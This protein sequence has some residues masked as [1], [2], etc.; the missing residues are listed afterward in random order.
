MRHHRSVF[1]R[2]A[3]AMGAAAVATAAV[4]PVASAQQ[5]PVGVGT[6]TGEL[7]VLG[8]QAGSLLSIQALSDGGL[9]TTADGLGPAAAAQLDALRITSPALGIDLA[10]P[11]L[12][13]ATNGGSDA[14]GGD[15]TPIDNPVLGGS[16]LPSAL[17]ALVDDT[18]ARSSVTAGL[19]DLDLLGGLLRLAGTQLDLGSIAESTAA[20][21]TRGVDVDAL[22]VL[23]LDALLTGLGIPLSS[24]PLDSL[25]G[26]VE[27]LGLLPEL[28]TTLAGLGLPGLDLDDLSVEGI[29]GVVGDLTG[30]LGVLVDSGLL[31]TQPVCDVA[32][33][34]LGLLG[35]LLGQD[36]GTLCA[37]VDA[38]VGQLTSQVTALTD[39]LAAAL[40]APLDVLDGAALLSLDGLDVEVLTRATDDVATS[41]AEVTGTLGTLRVGELS[42]GA[43]DLGATVGQLEGLIGQVEGTIGSVLSTIDPALADLVRISTLEQATSVVEDAGSVV[44]TAAFTGL[45]VEVLPNLAELT[46]LLGGLGGLTT[47]GDQLT[48]LGLPLPTG[49]TELLDFGTLLSAVPTTGLVTDGIVAALSEGLVFEVASL[50]QASTFTPAAVPGQVPTTPMLPRTGSEGTLVLALGV[51]AVLGA[52]TGRAAL[53]RTV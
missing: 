22:T 42:L 47:I 11:L 53:R 39:D 9:A 30:D 44:A 51:L 21:G 33:P 43:L 10:L 19:V 23:D 5:A 18:G 40:E 36:A 15:V 8:I 28:G 24:L 45:R 3:A 48:G 31:S 7:T 50:T 52:L 37:D 38:T 17:A 29:L 25:L 49:V 13:A 2:A 35:G 26:L 41:L 32:E 4:A 14:A 20:S 27:G 1:I 6:T 34:A 46:S 12:E 16:I